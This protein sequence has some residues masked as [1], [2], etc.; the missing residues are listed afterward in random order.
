MSRQ[1]PSFVTVFAH[2]TLGLLRD[3]QTIISRESSG[4]RENQNTKSSE[5]HKI[6][7]LLLLL[8]IFSFYLFTCPWPSHTA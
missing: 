4:K 5:D 2:G 3:T 8:K 1:F 7:F 6:V